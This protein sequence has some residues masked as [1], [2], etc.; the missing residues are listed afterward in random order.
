MGSPFQH[1]ELSPP[2][3][4]GVVSFVFATTGERD[5]RTYEEHEEGMICRVLLDERLY[6]LADYSVPEWKELGGGGSINLDGG[7][8]DTTYYAAT[9]D[10]GNAVN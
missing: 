1:R 4:H 10:G 9:V 2:N 5:S 6:W 8:A 7:E 3:I